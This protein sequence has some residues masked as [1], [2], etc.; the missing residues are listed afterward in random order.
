MPKSGP[1]NNKIQILTPTV[2]QDAYGAP[3]TTWAILHEMWA[4][5]SPATGRELEIAGAIGA[6]ITHGI[7]MR[8][9][10]GIKPK[11][12]VMYNGR[13]FEIISVQNL[14]ENN[15]ELRLQCK[16]VIV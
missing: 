4:A 15:Y 14:N 8:Y 2:T 9:V 10:A 16:E 7:T 12:K 11:C 3:V 6:D 5:I 1:L 13:T